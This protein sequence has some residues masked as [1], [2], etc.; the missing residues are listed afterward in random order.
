MKKVNEKET[1]NKK[2]VATSDTMV[3]MPLS[4]VLDRQLNINLKLGDNYYFDYEFN[5][6]GEI[7][8]WNVFP[9]NN[10]VMYDVYAMSSSKGD[11]M[12]DLK[13]FIKENKTYDIAQIVLG[14]N[15]IISVLLLILVIINMI[16]IKSRL[17]AYMVMGGNVVLII[18]CFV[19]SHYATKDHIHRMKYL[20]N[21]SEYR[22]KEMEGAY[23][24]IEK[25]MLKKKDAKKKRS[26]A[27]KRK[28]NN[29]DGNK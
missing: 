20:R 23:E 24:E 10:D 18:T 13:K 28:V 6:K 12:S 17:I 9:R 29:K 1:K 8:G 25:K 26:G 14:M 15:I 21:R 22:L 2:N 19:V 5:D 3:S 16:F 11:T 4:E 7:V 27:S